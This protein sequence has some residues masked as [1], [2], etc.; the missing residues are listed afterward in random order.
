MDNKWTPIRLSVAVK[1]KK[2]LKFMT[3][4]LDKYKRQLYL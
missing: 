2:E 1:D 4:Q 3:D